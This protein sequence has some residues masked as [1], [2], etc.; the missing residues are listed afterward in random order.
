MYMGP[1]A[2]LKT[3]W[4]F[5]VACF[6]VAGTILLGTFSGHYYGRPLVDN[7]P[8]MGMTFPDIGARLSLPARDSLGKTL[9]QNGPAFLVTVGEC[10]SCAVNRLE[11]SDLPK[12][13]KL[14][15]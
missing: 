5:V 4:F 6:S 14:P 1:V 8:L 2:P 12:I 10:S 13:S 11:S 15:I 3:G 9:P 7:A